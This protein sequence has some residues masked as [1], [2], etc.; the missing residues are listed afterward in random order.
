MAAGPLWH[1]WAL[2]DAFITGVE[3]QKKVQEELDEDIHLEY[4]T[5]LERGEL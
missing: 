4:K 2:Q 1:G 3:Y 5:R